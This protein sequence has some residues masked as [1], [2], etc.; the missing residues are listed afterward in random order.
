MLFLAQLPWYLVFA[1]K[2]N[3]GKIPENTA[4]FLFYQ[5]THETRR[6]DGEGLGA[7]LTTRGCGPGLAT[8]SGG[9]ATLATSSSPP[10]RLHIPFDLKLLGVR[11]FSQIEF[12]CAATIRNRDSELETPF[13]HPTGTGIWR[14]SSSPSSPTSLHQPSM[15]LPSMCE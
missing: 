9:E 2:S 7:R 5:K 4:K 10:F 3:S 12:R 8:L 15:T 1:Q 14:R 13:R 11:H 6:R